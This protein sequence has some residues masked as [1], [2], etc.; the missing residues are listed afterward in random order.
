MF[1]AQASIPAANL[2]KPVSVSL[3]P[4]P[5]DVRLVPVQGVTLAPASVR[6]AIA[7]RKVKG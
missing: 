1:A 5:V 7:P 4:V 6:V 3:K 2:T